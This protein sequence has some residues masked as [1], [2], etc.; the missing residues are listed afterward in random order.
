VFNPRVTLP[1]RRR[2]PGARGRIPRGRALP[3]ALALLLVPAYAATAGNGSGGEAGDAVPAGTARSAT[4]PTS[5]SPAAPDPGQTLAEALRPLTTSATG[6]FSVAVRTGDGTV[7]AA[8][9]SAKQH[10]YATAS[11]AKA[12][13][14]ATL[15][16]QAQDGHR[17][18]TASERA[19]AKLMITR[20]DN[21]SADT[22]WAGIGSGSGFASAIERLGLRETTPGPGG[23]WG[24]T[25]TTAA[26]QLR[27][28]D[29]LTSADSPLTAKSRALAADLMGEV[30]PDQDWGVSAAADENEPARLKN[31]W[32]PRSATGLWVVNS[33][34]I[35]T[36]E[37]HHLLLAVL[38]DDQRSMESG[39]SLV[40]SAA[41]AAAGAAERI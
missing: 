6:H 24:L 41:K 4:P 38:S 21:A 31:G 10:T 23:H 9:G 13:I 40:E 34:G 16:L 1:S 8:Y 26:D 29:S 32:L 5:Q 35:V 28:L 18:L 19:A 30:V 25:E 20:S 12:A 37:G 33:I 3:A 36:H 2:F 17:S 27:L 39:I 11:I 7:T 22:L 15:L 14:L